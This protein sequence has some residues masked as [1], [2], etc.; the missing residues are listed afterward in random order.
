MRLV[1]LSPLPLPQVKLYASGSYCEA[2]NAIE[3]ILAWKHG[4]RCWETPKKL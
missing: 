3:L 2:G 4:R 1:E